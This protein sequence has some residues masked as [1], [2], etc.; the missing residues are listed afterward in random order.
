[1]RLGINAILL[2]GKRTGVGRY[3]ESL[4]REWSLAPSGVEFIL[5]YLNEEPRDAFLDAPQFTRRR[6]GIRKLGQ[7]DVFEWELANNPVD[8]F[9]SPLYDLPMPLVPPAVITI[10]DMIHEAFPESFNEVQL[11]YLR[12]KTA[13]GVKMADVIITDSLFSREEITARFPGAAGK[14]E[15][16][17]LAP[18]PLF[19]VAEVEAGFMEKRFGVK[20]PFIF[21]VG[22]VTPKRHIRPLFEAFCRIA[23]RYPQWSVITIGRNV[24]FPHEN[25]DELTAGYNRA[26]GRQALIYEEFVSDGDLLKLYNKADI[27][28]YLSTYEGFGMPPLEAM[29]CGAPVITSTA[30]S[31]P[32]VVGDGALTV[33]PFDAGEVTEGLSRLMGD[34]I[35]RD[36]LREKGFLRVK[37]FSWAATAE[38]TLSAIKKAFAKGV[39]AS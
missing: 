17:P 5:Y 20:G 38:K 6:I 27:F 14:I 15:V 35:L 2:E 4:L 26:I 24:T 21:Y 1:M 29:A 37:C 30:S 25:L 32:E 39:K 11:S 36:R 8:M 10:H 23:S 28:A 9:F 18:S 34:Q 3:L 31:L 13:Y 7:S 12:E 22:A 19:K 33:N 16:I